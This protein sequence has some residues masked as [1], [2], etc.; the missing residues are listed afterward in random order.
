[1]TWQQREEPEDRRKANA[2][3]IFKKSRKDDP[4]NYNQMKISGKMMG[5][6]I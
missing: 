5:S 4:G 3:S 6:G 2:T 1:M